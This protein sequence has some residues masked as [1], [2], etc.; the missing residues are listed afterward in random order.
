M[1]DGTETMSPRRPRI[2]ID[3]IAFE[4]LRRIAPSALAA[5]RPRGD[6]AGT[7]AM[8]EEIAFKLTQRCDLRCAHCYQW[9]EAG[10]HHRMRDGEPG[11]DLDPEVIARVLAATRDVRS[12]V[13]LWGGEPL[14]YRH[15]DRLADMLA[16]D[17]RWVSLCTNGS[18]IERR[19]VSLCAISRTLEIVL[20]IDGFDDAHDRLRGAG[21]FAR[22]LDGLAALR[23]ARERGAFRGEITVNT[24]FNDAMPGRITAFVAYLEQAGVDTVYLSYPWHLNQAACARMDQWVDLHLPWVR[25]RAIAGQPSWHAYRYTLDPARL[26][27]LD[28]DLANLE[29]RA[30]RIKL[31]FNPQVNPSRRH[32]FLAGSDRPASGVRRCLSLRTRMDIFPNGDVVSCKFYPEFVVGNLSATGVADAWQSVRFEQVRDTL[33]R[34]GLM[35]VCAKC[36]L[37]YARGA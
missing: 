4:K 19:L 11:Q 3:R 17:P 13:Y 1:N 25:E 20:A 30:W 9:G 2:A 29:R 8:P 34:E 22:V 23:D 15:W 10:Y 27:A 35:P 24:V 12:N 21:A 37:L 36:N 31:R 5:R 26:T 18:L 32:E 6:A 7:P 16:D 28:A 33:D 14:V